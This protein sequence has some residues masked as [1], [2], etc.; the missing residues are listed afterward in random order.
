MQ[1]PFHEGELKIQK[2]A[3]EESIA[4]RNGNMIAERVMKGALPFL[5]STIDGSVRVA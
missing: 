2:L 3:G 5:G 4:E 1:S